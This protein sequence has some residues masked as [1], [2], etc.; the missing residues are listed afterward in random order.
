MIVLWPARPFT[1]S[2]TKLKN[3]WEKIGYNASAVRFGVVFDLQTWLS[4]LHGKS[5]ISQLL[6]NDVDYILKKKHKKWN[7]EE[8]E[9]NP[10]KIT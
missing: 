4:V 1:K 9:R 8:W 7:K 6:T 10:V 3:E 5:H 2:A